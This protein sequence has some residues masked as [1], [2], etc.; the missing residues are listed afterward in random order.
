MSSSRPSL[1]IEL[2]A[3]RAVLDVPESAS[4][5]ATARA[6]E[7]TRQVL[8]ALRPGLAKALPSNTAIIRRVAS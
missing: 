2:V 5:A 6:D 3:I 8:S 1:T 7:F 4:P